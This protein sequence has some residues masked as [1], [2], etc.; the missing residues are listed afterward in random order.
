[1]RILNRVQVKG[2]NLW[3]KV[4]WHLAVSGLRWNPE[5]ERLEHYTF[6]GHVRSKPGAV[7]GK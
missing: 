5:A 4:R 1:M 6:T 7:W 3:R 2:K